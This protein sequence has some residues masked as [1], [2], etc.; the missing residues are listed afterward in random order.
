MERKERLENKAE[1]QE[2]RTERKTARKSNKKVLDIDID[3]KRVDVEIDR[4]KDGNLD[5]K[6]DGKHVDGH[7]KK[8]GDKITLE[9]EIND[10]DTYLFEGNGSNRRLPKGAVWKLTGAVIKTFL[11][12]KWGKIKKR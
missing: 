7:Y 4:D 12:R 9:V 8:E 3:T 1:R 11:N 10:Q 2:K 5:V 6:W